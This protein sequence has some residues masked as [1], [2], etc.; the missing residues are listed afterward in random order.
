MSGLK[1]NYEKSEVFVL[2]CS[3]EEQKSAA[4]MFNCNIGVLPLEYLGILVNN[5]HMS[6]ADLSYVHIK[7]EKKVPTWQSVGLSSGGKMILTESCLSSIPTYTMGIYHLQEEIHHKM[8]MAGA[9]FFWHGPHQKRKYHM[10]KWRVMASP[11]EVGG[12]GFTDTRVMNICLLTK[13]LV[14][15]ERGDDTL[16]CNL[17][18]QKYLEEKIIYSY[19]KNSGSQ[20]WRG[21]LSI[22]GEAARGLIYIIG[23]G[24]KARFWMDVWIGK[25][26]LCISFP[27]LFEICNQKEWSIC[28]VLNNGCINLTF[29]SSFGVLH[30]QEW[31]ELSALIEGASLTDLP[32]S[33]RW[34]LDKKGFFTTASLYREIFYTGF[35]NRWMMSIWKAKIPL[36]IMIFLW[37]V[38]NDKIQSAEQLKKRNWEGPIEC[39]MCG[40][41]EST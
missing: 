7:V 34:C 22:R 39:K 30:M 15:L 5:K 17:L 13:W 37:Q 18:R 12:A 32:E 14:K 21:L 19:K 1:I 24:K 10:A 23:D 35:E 8:D 28:K 41:I 25:C 11:K 26:A 27:N 31:A 38:C 40:Q 6:A 36:K 9:N 29:R 2:G 33:V 3:D 16:C 4:E 20:F